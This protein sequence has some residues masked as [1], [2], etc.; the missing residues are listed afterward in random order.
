M[1]YEARDIYY[2]LDEYVIDEAIGEYMK[3]K[4]YWEYEYEN[5][6]WFDRRKALVNKNGWDRLVEIVWNWLLKDF[7]RHWKI[8]TA[9]E[10]YQAHVE[11]YGK[12]YDLKDWF[13]HIKPEYDKWIE[14]EREKYDT[15]YEWEQWEKN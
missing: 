3:G 12:E 10:E 15:K 4:P 9:Q 2:Y 1:T 5:L 14:K 13:E 7:R 11:Y 6:D 8:T